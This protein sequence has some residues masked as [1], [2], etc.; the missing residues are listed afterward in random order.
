[1]S[2][3]SGPGSGPDL[4]PDRTLEERLY[5]AHDRFAL[6]VDVFDLQGL[7]GVGARLFRGRP[8]GRGAPLASW[9]PPRG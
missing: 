1:M 5:A 6:L 3:T 9:T 2:A 8:S 4:E 7:A